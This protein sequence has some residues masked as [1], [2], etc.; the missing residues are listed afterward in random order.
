VISDLISAATEGVGAQGEA[1][2]HAF[3]AGADHQ[4]REDEEAQGEASG[5]PKGSRACCSA[6]S[7]VRVLTALRNS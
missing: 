6:C 5:A 4:T 3:A 7:C 2:I 1:G